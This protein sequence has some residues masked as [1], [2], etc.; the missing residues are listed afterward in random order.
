MK[1]RIWIDTYASYIQLTAPK[2]SNI[3]APMYIAYSVL[4]D[5]QKTGKDLPDNNKL[6]KRLEGYIAACDKYRNE[7]AA[8]QKYIPGWTPPFEL[9]A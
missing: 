3:T 5:E 8:I 1:F 7:I 6:N 9:K 4:R 2:T